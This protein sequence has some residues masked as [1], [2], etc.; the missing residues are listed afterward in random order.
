[1]KINVELQ[2][3]PLQWVSDLTFSDLLWLQR[4][5]VTLDHQSRKDIEHVLQRTGSTS[6]ASSDGNS[7]PFSNSRGNYGGSYSSRGKYGGHAN[8]LGDSKSGIT[9]NIQESVRNSPSHCSE[10]SAG[11]QSCSR[12]TAAELSGPTT[13][14][15]S[16]GRS[17]PMDDHFMLEYSSNLLENEISNDLHGYDGRG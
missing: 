10:A 6:A 16:A 2:C 4:L 12:S 13:S 3:G 7:E 8:H 11:N 5:H 17:S 1:M 15:Y 9:N 14:H